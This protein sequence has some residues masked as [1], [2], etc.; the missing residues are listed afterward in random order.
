MLMFR[1]DTLITQGRV[2]FTQCSNYEPHQVQQTVTNNLKGFEQKQVTNRNIYKNR[3]VGVCD[4][5]KAIKST[6]K[7]V[8]IFIV[9]TLL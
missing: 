7:F 8:L 4:S 5:K 2:I 1:K 6:I 3:F 9:N